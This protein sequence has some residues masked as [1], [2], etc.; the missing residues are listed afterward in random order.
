[1]NV[2]KL[3]EQDKVTVSDIFIHPLFPSEWKP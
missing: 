1:M 3:T 2:D